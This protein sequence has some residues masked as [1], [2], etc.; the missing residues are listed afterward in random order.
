MRLNGPGKYDDACAQAMA[1]TKAVG[2]LMIVI[3]GNKG[4]GVSFKTLDPLVIGAMPTLLRA[5][6]DEIEKDMGAK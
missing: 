2:V 1:T 5:L 4:N 3:E 6:A